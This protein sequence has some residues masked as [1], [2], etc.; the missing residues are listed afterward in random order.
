M[1]HNIQEKGR[2]IPLPLLTTIRKKHIETYKKEK[3]IKKV[4]DIQ[5]DSQLR[6]KDV[7]FLDKL[8]A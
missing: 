6:T 3:E 1:V 4:H 7:H 8:K 2:K 5:Y